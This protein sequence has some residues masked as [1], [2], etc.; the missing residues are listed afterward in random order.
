[1]PSVP[2][3]LGMVSME[4]AGVYVPYNMKDRGMVQ[5]FVSAD[6][7]SL[8]NTTGIRGAFNAGGATC[9]TPRN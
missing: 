9:Y 7:M 8:R 2:H 5:L 6:E 1:M 3:P 4:A